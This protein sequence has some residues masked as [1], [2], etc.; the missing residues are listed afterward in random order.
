MTHR[1]SRFAVL[2]LMVAAVGAVVAQDDQG[3]KK[4]DAPPVKPA[5]KA[6]TP[7]TLARL[8]T[9]E[10]NKLLGEMLEYHL[11]RDFKGK[12]TLL[13]ALKGIDPKVEAI[14][15]KCKF[16]MADGKPRIE[17]DARPKK[18]DPAAEAALRELVRHSLTEVST[19]GYQSGSDT[20]R[21][22]LDKALIG[23]LANGVEVRWGDASTPGTTPGTT[24]GKPPIAPPVPGDPVRRLEARL[25]ASE[26]QVIELRKQG[27]ELKSQTARLQDQVRKLEEGGGRWNM[28]QGLPMLLDWGCCWGPTTMWEV[29]PWAVPGSAKGT[30]KLP[31]RL[32]TKG[33]K[34]TDAD[35]LFW[36]GHRD[37]FAADYAE[38][39]QSFDAVTQ[40]A[41]GD[42]RGWY[43]RALA[44]RAL[45]QEREAEES[46]KAGAKA[47][48]QGSSPV[49]LGRAL[50]RVQGAPRIWLRGGK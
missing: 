41:P 28:V 22:T 5:D 18:A 46:R 7:I 47:Q 27:E 39:W 8:A 1:G 45:G 6:P 24:P 14:P 31:V 38:A 50:E 26:K 36:V 44:E 43:F 30:S 42:A 21:Y 33:W 2:A 16:S 13:D 3:K 35:K 37:F 9:P 23:P 48:A 11:R 4:D 19:N 17:C 49:E 40:L 34:R 12:Q 20:P 15:A 29:S 32:S 25:A 10:G